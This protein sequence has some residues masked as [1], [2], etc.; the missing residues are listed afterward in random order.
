MIYRT[1]IN[2]TLN[3]IISAKYH[4]Q[5]IS[6]AFSI[7]NGQIAGCYHIEAVGKDRNTVIFN[8]S[9]PTQRSFKTQ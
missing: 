7:E 3:G 5:Y 2:I 9:C 1:A 4:Y 8:R 6:P